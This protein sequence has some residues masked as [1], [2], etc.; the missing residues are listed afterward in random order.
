MADSGGRYVTQYEYDNAM[1]RKRE[2]DE[3]RAKADSDLQ[4]ARIRLEQAQ[5]DL[6]RRNGFDKRQLQKVLQEE[7]NKLLRGMDETSLELRRAIGQQNVALRKQLDEVR[8]DVA[9]TNGKI[10]SVKE[11]IS[12]AKC[13]IDEVEQRVSEVGKRFGQE[14]R[15]IAERL[16]KERDRAQYYANTFS[17]LLEHIDK[18][19]PEKLTPGKAEILHDADRFVTVNLKNG[20]YQAAIGLAQ[21]KIADAISLQSELERLNDEYNQLV[22]DVREQLVGVQGHIRQLSD[23]KGNVKEIEI[24]KGDSI[25]DFTFDGDIAFWTSGLFPQLC[26]QFSEEQDTIENEF[27]LEMDLDNLKAALRKLPSY[28]HK[29]NRCLEFAREEFEMSG[30]QQ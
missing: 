19:H 29:L 15:E 21:S 14:L 16:A 2:A 22:L 10:E 28:H 18:L 9:V 20:D 5:N 23:T 17:L 13:A 24:G 6:A 3:R 1:R 11:D 26:S 12:Q 8:H 7:E 30:R 25:Y 4:Q 27:I